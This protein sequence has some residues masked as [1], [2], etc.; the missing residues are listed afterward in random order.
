MTEGRWSRERAAAWYAGIPWPVGC[1][2][3]PATAVNQL[4]MWQRETFDEE[5]ID[6]ELSR[7][8]GL[9]FNVLRVFL[10]DLAWLDDAEGFKSRLGRFLAAA[11]RHGM[12]AM[13]VL[14]DDCWHADP[15]AGPQPRPVPGVH[16]SRWLQSPG[17]R[18]VRDRLSWNRLEA[19]VRDVVGAFAADDRVLLWDLYN[20]PDNG[21]LPLLSLPQ[22]GKSFRLA[23]AVLR[24]ALLPSRCLPLLRRVFSWARAARPR[25]PLTAGL[26][27]LMKPSVARFLLAECDVVSFHNYG[28]AR[29]LEAEIRRLTARG[30]PVLCTEYMARTAGSLFET[31]LPVFQREKVACMSWGLVAG[32]TQTIWSWKDRGSAGEPEVWYHDIFRRDGSPFDPE[33]VELIRRHTGKTG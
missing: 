1:N 18:A 5:T 2:Y 28:D 30:R 11:A 8:E 23:G 12:R 7:A 27:S 21:F 14:F 20:E 13:P 25:Q 3:V 6:R 24:H 10:H 31:H 22:P 26:W 19:Y 9:G 15:A 32:K 17:R 16:N 33:E 4:E 29:S